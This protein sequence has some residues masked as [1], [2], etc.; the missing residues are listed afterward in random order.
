MLKI[1]NDSICVP[2]QM[3]FKQALRNGMFRSEWKKGNIAAIHK[4]SDNQNIKNYR[5]VSLLPICGKTSFLTRCLTISVNKLILKSSPV[6]NPVIPVLINYYQL[7][8]KLLH[9]L[10]MD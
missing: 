1:C 4:K 9:L 10:I 7:T 5:P 8:T 2:L 3:I 6:S